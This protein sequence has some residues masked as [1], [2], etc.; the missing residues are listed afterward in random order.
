MESYV[1]LAGGDERDTPPRHVV[2]GEAGNSRW[3]F[4]AANP[5]ALGP[6]SINANIL[7]S[8]A[9]PLAGD[10]ALRRQEFLEYARLLAESSRQIIDQLGSSEASG[11]TARDPGSSSLQGSAVAVT[12]R[13]LAAQIDQKTADQR[14]IPG[15]S[16]E[17]TLHT[18]APPSSRHSSHATDK[19]VTR[20][21]RVG[22]ANNTNFENELHARLA[23]TRSP[24]ERSAL[25]PSENDIQGHDIQRDETRPDAALQDR[26][27]YEAAAQRRR[28]E[29][30]QVLDKRQRVRE[31][32]RSEYRI[33]KDQL[34]DQRTQEAE[35]FRFRRAGDIAEIAAL[36]RDED[37][38]RREITQMIEDRIA[39]IR[40]NA[41]TATD[42]FLAIQTLKETKEHSF[43][44]DQANREKKR[45]QQIED[46]QRRIDD[47]ASQVVAHVR[48]KRNS[49]IEA[50]EAF[51]NRQTE[52]IK[53]LGIGHDQAQ[54]HADDAVDQVVAHIREKR[55]SQIEASE[56]FR[57]RQ[58]ESI[59]SQQIDYEKAQQR[60]D[61]AVDQVVTH[62]REKR[63]SQIEAA[64]AFRDQ[65][66]ET[67][68]SQRID[69]DDSDH[70]Q[71]RMAQYRQQEDIAQEKNF[72][73]KLFIED[74][75]NSVIRNREIKEQENIR[76]D[77]H[78]NDQYE[79]APTK[80]ETIGRTN[81]LL[82]DDERASIN[83]NNQIRDKGNVG[84]PETTQAEAIS[85]DRSPL[86]DDE[87]ASISRKDKVSDQENAGQNAH[88]PEATKAE[89]T[90]QD[91]RTL[92]DDEPDLA[93]RSRIVTDQENTDQAYF[94]HPP[95]KK[96]FEESP[97][98]ALDAS[99]DRLRGD[100]DTD[101]DDYQTGTKA[102]DLRSDHAPPERNRGNDRNDDHESNSEQQPSEDEEFFIH[103]QIMNRQAQREAAESYA[104]RHDADHHLNQ[105]RRI[106]ERAEHRRQIDREQVMERHQA[107]DSES[108]GQSDSEIDFA[109]SG[110][111]ITE[112]ASSRVQIEV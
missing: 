25:A 97:Q 47:A 48:E 41:N 38:Y 84:Q 67:I 110:P 23:P 61:D 12:A 54:Q 58:T 75:Q 31:D 82:S 100:S 44:R 15:S 1:R 46:V 95:T 11:Q 55:N 112:A 98:T 81:P 9:A 102:A 106:E 6:S 87:H 89:I 10:A 72:R 101:F 73:R 90:N 33:L 7:G 3:L 50:S 45:Q 34:L 94:D 32:S 42:R 70:R 20:E 57:D 26:A 17:T 85:R 16:P 71:Q 93:I 108:G 5:L 28:G 78:K 40:S 14:K 29:L 4:M 96:S 19:A 109:D 62:I 91:R 105:D 65:H 36:Q 52:S 104:A 83:R 107:G 69:H 49:Q 60:A 80:A 92:S 35:A 68:K 13:N 8:L 21:H 103:Q 56:A 24:L 66:I 88:Q 30:D 99:A 74:H 111:I 27:F 2:R 76:D 37:R 39:R 53:S 59:K 64:Q 63:N 77:Q 51:R 86:S 22:N 43:H 79:T 18:Y